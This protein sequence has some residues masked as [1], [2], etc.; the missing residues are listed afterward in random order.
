MAHEKFTTK[1]L[2]TN[3]GPIFQGTYL[4]RRELHPLC[5]ERNYLKDLLAWTCSKSFWN[6]S[7]LKSKLLRSIKKMHIL[8]IT[9]KI[10]SAKF[11]PDIERQV[12]GQWILPLI[13]CQLLIREFMSI[14]LF[15]KNRNNWKRW[16]WCTYMVSNYGLSIKHLLHISRFCSIYFCCLTTQIHSCWSVWNSPNLA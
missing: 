12:N 9:F 5:K 8:I 3:K 13:H 4:I 6:L 10:Q 14:F 16:T 7:R 2:W 1:I 15:M 11:I